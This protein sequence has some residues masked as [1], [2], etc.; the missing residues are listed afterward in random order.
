M[1]G[2]FTLFKLTSF[3]WSCVVC[4]YLLLDFSEIFSTLAF[5]D[6]E[7]RPSDKRRKEEKDEIAAFYGKFVAVVVMLLL[8]LLMLL[9]LLLLLLMLLLLYKMMKDE[10]KRRCFNLNFIPFNFHP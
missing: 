9:L 3:K 2:V 10:W 1:H 5:W 8:F 7:D 6:G 4:S